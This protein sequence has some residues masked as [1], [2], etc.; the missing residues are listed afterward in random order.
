[1]LFSDFR[2]RVQSWWVPTSRH[3]LLS[4]QRSLL[5][6]F[7]PKHVR[8]S[9]K[10][11]KDGFNYVVVEN[12]QRLNNINDDV[13]QS[14]TTAV[15][16]RAKSK[17]ST[18][19]LLHGFGSGLGFF[20]ANYEHLSLTFDRVVAV[21]WLG[22][23]GSARMPVAAS[24]RQTIADIV[25]GGFTGNFD[26]I[27]SVTVPRSIDFFIDSLENFC[28]EQGDSM[29]SFVIAGHSLGG[30]LAARFAERY[31]ERVQ[32]LILI[33]PCGVPQLPPPEKRLTSNAAPFGLQLFSFMVSKGYQS[34]E[35]SLLS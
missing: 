35:V 33:S 27:D 19:L 34:I 10:E 15:T 16:R 22:M 8:I 17:R 5:E 20:F 14:N 7:V 30:Y 31:R 26:A 6:H 4:A 13:T 9:Y 32:A 28:V 12:P 18:L 23:G 29:D 2:H 21:D 1:M 3:L 24:P 25:Y 11:S